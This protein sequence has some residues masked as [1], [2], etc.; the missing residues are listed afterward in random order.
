MSLRWKWSRRLGMVNFGGPA[1][2]TSFPARGPCGSHR[3]G[4]MNCGVSVGVSGPI[5][6]DGCLGSRRPGGQLA[7][8]ADDGLVGE[9]FN[10]LVQFPGLGRALEVWVR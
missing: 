9:V 1:A 6:L 3:Q 10:P 8:V 7:Q 4:L 5:P 2:R